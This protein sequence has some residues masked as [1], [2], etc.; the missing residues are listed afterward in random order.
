MLIDFET[1]SPVGSVK[2]WN[3]GK[4]GFSLIPAGSAVNY[5]DDLIAFKNVFLYYFPI[6]TK[7]RK[8]YEINLVIDMLIQ[9]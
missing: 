9:H 6:K 3:T 8:E 2:P 7:D 1:L 4:L 5:W